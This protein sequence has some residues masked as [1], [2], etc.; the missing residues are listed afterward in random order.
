MSFNLISE[1][2]Q[3][4]PG[5][6]D[7]SECP[8]SVE[9]KHYFKNKIEIQ[10]MVGGEGAPDLFEGEDKLLVIDTQVMAVINDLEAFGKSLTAS[11]PNEKM[12]YFRTKTALLEKLVTMRERIAN[13]KEINDFRNIMISF[14]TEVCT[15]DQVTTLM[16]RLDGVLGTSNDNFS[17]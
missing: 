13:L 12:G 2:L 15:K 10:S 1:G 8:Y 3:K 17:G 9:I 14:M 7:S 11:D 16:H 6:L 4:D 5:Y